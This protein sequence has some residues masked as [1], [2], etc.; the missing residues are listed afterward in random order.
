MTIKLLDAQIVNDL[1]NRN[2]S[3]ISNRS[4]SLLLLNGLNKDK[5][6]IAPSPYLREGSWA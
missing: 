5:E 2:R 3:S 1:A 6:V 4:D